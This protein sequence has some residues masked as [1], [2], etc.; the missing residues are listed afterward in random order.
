MKGNS[1]TFIA[2]LGSGLIHAI[3]EE[4]TNNVKIIQ[5]MK[6]IF[7]IKLNQKI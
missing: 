1:K 7:L 2:P 5:K 6:Q 4:I 3:F